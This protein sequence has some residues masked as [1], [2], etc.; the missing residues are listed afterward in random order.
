MELVD[1]FLKKL[2]VSRNNFATYILSLFTI[3]ILVD[4]VVEM[5]LMIFTGVSSSYWGPF[6]YTF[7]LACPIFAFLFACSSSYVESR[8]SK[9]TFF[10]TAMIAFYV[11]ALSMFTQWFNMGFWLL[12]ISVPNYVKIVTE[13]SSLVRPAFSALA[14]YLPLVTIYPFAT[15]LIFYVDDTRTMTKS[16][17]DYRGIDLSNKKAKHGPYACDVCFLTDADVGKKITFPEARRFQSLFVCGASGTGKTAM[18]FEPIIAQ[19]IEKKYFFREAAK[20]LGF[21]AL[22]T[23]IANLSAPYSNDYLNENFSLNMLSPSLGKET[24]FKTFMKKAILSASPN[25][26]YKDL[27]I[28]YMS[29]DYETLEQMM[30]VCDNYGIKY[31]VVDP[32]QPEKS[33]G[34]NP[35]VYDEPTK[36]AMTISTTLQSISANNANEIKDAYREDIILQIIENVSILLKVMYPKLH[37]NVLPNL[38]D[39][40]TLLSNFELVEKMCEI[41]NKDEELRNEYQIQISY[42]KRNFYSNGKSRE[43]TEKNAY[44][45]TSKLENL[46]RTPSIKN[47]LCNRHNNINFDNSLQNGN[48]LF[49]CTR[50]GETGKVAHKAFGLFFLLSMQNAVLRRP[51]NENS[52]IPHFL[53]ID[54]FPDFY[55]KDTET[56]FTMYRKYKVATTISAQSITMVANGN[57]LSTDTSKEQNITI[58]FTSPVLSNCAN[59]VFTGGASIDELNWWSN[60]IGKWKQ[61]KYTQ[62]YD[63]AKD[64]MASTYGNPQFEYTIKMKPNRLQ[65]LPQNKCGFKILDDSGW[66]QIGEGKMNYLGSKYKE[67]H[68]SKKYNFAKYSNKASNSNNDFEDNNKK[69]KFDPKNVDF[70]DK[71]MDGEFDPIKHNDDSKFIY[72]NDDAIIVNLKPDKK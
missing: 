25:I 65:A 18:V 38:E 64:E 44:Y 39:L 56:M 22:K 24:L 19:D 21:T 10:Y 35:F 33:L 1:K 14:L 8:K 52:R 55:C 60:E 58:G 17:E 20:E 37:D 32:L 45:I 51:G 5:L 27:G 50:R 57:S 71:N 2:N 62:N 72:N 4:R 69:Q 26:V 40:L 66:N 12:F 9:I 36:I 30:S 53:Y 42:F 48:V 68:P 63:G 16:I 46:L 11:I 28:T 34:L 3:Y 70:R 49:L 15:K 59:K 23:G 54:E 43:E 29:P 13:F 7:A 47:I 61:W 41:M 67:H 31:D 6:K